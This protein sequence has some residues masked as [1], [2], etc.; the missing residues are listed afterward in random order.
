MIE[1]SKA[2]EKL[3]NLFNIKPKK[4]TLDTLKK[5][6]GMSEG[7]RVLDKLFKKMIIKIKTML[8]INLRI[9]MIN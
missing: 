5:N 9:I 4:D 7:F 1:I 3:D 6:S 2:V 8:L